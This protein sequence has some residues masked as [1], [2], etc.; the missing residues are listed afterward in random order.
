MNRNEFALSV[1][2]GTWSTPPLA[3]L[4]FGVGFIA[5]EINQKSTFRQ[6]VGVIYLHTPLDA[7][8]TAFAT[9]RA[10]HLSALGSGSQSRARWHSG[11]GQKKNVS[12]KHEGID[13]GVAASLA[14]PVMYQ[15]AGA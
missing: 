12:A 6:S 3:G 11:G 9:E 10:G 15:P 2:S 5:L 14:L 7:S 13:L 8:Q 4:T 1:I